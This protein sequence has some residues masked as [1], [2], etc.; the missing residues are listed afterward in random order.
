MIQ[1]FSTGYDHIFMRTLACGIL[2]AHQRY[3]QSTLNV[4]HSSGIWP[5]GSSLSLSA[6]PS[7]IRGEFVH[8][9]LRRSGRGCQEGHTANLK[10]IAVKKNSLPLSKTWE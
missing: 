8:Q 6:N 9:F 2:F 4:R 1:R 7:K 5:E 10:K 3:T